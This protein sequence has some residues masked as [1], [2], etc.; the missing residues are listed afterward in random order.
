MKTAQEFKKSRPMAQIFATFLAAFFLSGC[1]GFGGGAFNSTS[2]NAIGID[3]NADIDAI[4]YEVSKF[5]AN[6]AASSTAESLQDYVKLSDNNES[7]LDSIELTVKKFKNDIEMWWNDLPA[8]DTKTSPSRD[9]Y[10]KWAEGYVKWIYYQR[11]SQKL[12][13]A[14][15]VTAQ[16]KEEFVLC[17]INNLNRTMEFERLS[18]EDLNIAVQDIRDWSQSIGGN[19]G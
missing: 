9:K 13:S 16:T 10:L 14:C 3:L 17:T 11:E 7:I 1:T 5:D 4:A 8:E 2:A 15:T 6:S 19:N 18:K 12:G